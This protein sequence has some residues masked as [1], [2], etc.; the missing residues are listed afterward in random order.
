MADFKYHTSCSKCGSKNNLAVYSDGSYF[1]FSHCGNK[2]VSKEWIEENGDK[3]DKRFKVKPKGEDMV[4]EI[5]SSK[6]MI[7][8][9]EKQEIR[10]MT[11]FDDTDYRGISQETY[12][13]FG[14]RTGYDSDDEPMVH[15]YPCTQHSELVG[16]KKRELPKQFGGNIGRTGK[17]CELFGQFR[18]KQ[19]RSKYCLIVGG[20]LDVL[21]AYQMLTNYNQRRGSDFEAVVVSPTI[22][23]TGCE[24]QLAA[25]YEWFNQFER[26]IVGFDNDKAGKEATEKAI[27][28]LPKGKAFVAHWTH[29]DPN[30]YLQED[31][32]KLFINDYFNAEKYVPT[33]VLAS[34]HLYDKILQQTQTPKVR[35]PDFM[36]ALNDMFVDGMPLGHIVNIAA[37][38]GIGKTTL[39]NEMIYDWVF[40]SPHRVGVISMELDSGQY[41]EVLLSR[42]LRR[43][44]ALIGNVD[45]KLKLIKSETIKEKADELFKTPDGQ[46]R[47]Y[48]LDN[49]DGSVEE[50]QETVE[51]LLISCGCKLIVLDPLQDVLDGLSNEEQ[52]L[53]MKWAKGFIKSHNVLFV[54]INHMR[55]TPAGQSGGD[56]EQNIMGS[57]TII[58]SASANIL[59]RRDKM[60]E[61]PLVRNITWIDVPKNRVC[62]ITGPCGGVYYEND[63]HTLHNLDQYLNDNGLILPEQERKR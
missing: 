52:A 17:E 48:V 41:G 51:Q 1:C 45:E 10:D 9:E 44:L 27:S 34:E 25:Q 43:K 62:G 36:G 46:S 12:K 47:F 33:G 6:P 57:S 30:E 50:I 39:V 61:N 20:E 18:F 59:L 3:S 31:D 21:S 26:I 63:T 13:F 56:N 40:N 58:K 2:S 15:Y 28:A 23:E 16:Y 14:V 35:F 54:F 7:T 55:K 19:P 49:R 5:K 53:F 37:D 22:G 42:H 38:T 32:E 8:E 11:S 60:A 24:K 4:E 29:K